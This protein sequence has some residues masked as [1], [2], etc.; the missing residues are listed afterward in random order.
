MRGR[1]RINWRVLLAHVRIDLGYEYKR[2]N[3]VGAAIGI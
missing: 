1:E 3:G 2:G